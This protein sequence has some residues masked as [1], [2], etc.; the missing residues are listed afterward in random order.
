MFDPAGPGENL[1]VFL[2]RRGHG[3]IGIK[4]N[5][6][7]AGGPLVNGGNVSRH[8]CPVP[9]NVV[10]PICLII[11]KGGSSGLCFDENRRFGDGLS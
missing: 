2:L 6:T 9:Q 7:R 11:A 5:A 1:M 3:A 4:Q 8:G 10:I